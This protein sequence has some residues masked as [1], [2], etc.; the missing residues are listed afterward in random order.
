MKGLI[1]DCA[2]CALSLG[3]SSAYVCLGQKF[4]KA[5]TDVTVAYVEC[6]YAVILW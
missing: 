5:E 1:S 2:A 4:Q 3:L 6:N